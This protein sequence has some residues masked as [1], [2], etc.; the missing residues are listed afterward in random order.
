VKVSIAGR[1]EE[2]A[3]K[4]PA[5]SILAAQDGS[6]FVMVV[7]ADGAAHSKPV[8]LGIA[9]EEKVQVTGGL[10]LN[11]L[12]ITGGAYGLEDAVTKVK[13]GPAKDDDSKPAAGKGGENN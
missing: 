12:V 1:V 3:L 13:V 9:D 11:D 4:I 10:G 5:S 6:K 8:T 7:G 2:Q